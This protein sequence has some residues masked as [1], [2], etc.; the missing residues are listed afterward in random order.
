[1]ECNH[2]VFLLSPEKQGARPLRGPGDH[3]E[4]QLPLIYRRQMPLMNEDKAVEPSGPMSES[5]SAIFSAV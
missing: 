4:T 1:M 5:S 2:T 3:R